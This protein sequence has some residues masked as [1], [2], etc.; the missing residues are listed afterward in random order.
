M[1]IY[2]YIYIYM[3][4]QF[5]SITAASW[6]RMPPTQQLW[7]QSCSMVAPT[8]I[9]VLTLGQMHAPPSSSLSS[10]IPLSRY[11]LFS[12]NDPSQSLIPLS[13]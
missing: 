6:K 13:Q 5:T 11:L 12:V 2:I 3:S 9:L 1:C 7:K 4:S 10:M 8:S